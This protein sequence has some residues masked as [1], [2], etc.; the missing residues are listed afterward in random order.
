MY[1]MPVY[2]KTEVKVELLFLTFV[3]SQ[4]AQI[5]FWVLKSNWTH[6][7]P[8]YWLDTELSPVVSYD[9]VRGVKSSKTTL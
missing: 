8:G 6:D 7:L 3:T 2:S 4:V 1:R 5:K 9:L